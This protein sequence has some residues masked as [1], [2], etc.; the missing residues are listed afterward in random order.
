[1]KRATLQTQLLRFTAYVWLDTRLEATTQCSVLT[2][3]TRCIA[4]DPQVLPAKWTRSSC[5]DAVSPVPA[6]SA[7]QIYILHERQR[8][9]IACDPQPTHQLSAEALLKAR[10]LPHT[11]NT[12]SIQSISYSTN[13]RRNLGITSH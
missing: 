10:L 11:E 7:S 9:S 2:S 8:G 3:L 4:L 6:T 5:S 12:Q 13:S 1:M